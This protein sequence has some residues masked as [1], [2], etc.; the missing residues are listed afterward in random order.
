MARR[1]YEEMRA[2]VRDAIAAAGGEITHN[3]LVELLDGTTA[4]Q[5]IRMQHSGDIVPQVVALAGGGVELRYT[6]GVTN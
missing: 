3:A 4:Q 6:A 5:L 2:Q 1:T